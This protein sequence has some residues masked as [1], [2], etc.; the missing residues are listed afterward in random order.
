MAKLLANWPTAC[1]KRVNAKKRAEVD[2][3]MTACVPYF[4]GT[5]LFTPN[6]DVPDD[7]SLRLGFERNEMAPFLAFL[8]HRF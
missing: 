1:T 8:D 4:D 3:K 5:H 6:S 7:Q 2:K